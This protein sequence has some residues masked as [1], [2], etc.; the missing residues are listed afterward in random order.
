[1]ARAQVV[2][3]LTIQITQGSAGRQRVSGKTQSNSGFQWACLEL[4][5]DGRTVEHVGTGRNAIKYPE[6]GPMERHAM[7]RL[8]DWWCLLVR[9]EAGPE[10]AM[11]GALESQH[12]IN[13]KTEKR[14]T[15]SEIKP[16]FFYD[17]VVEVGLVRCDSEYRAGLIVC[18]YPI[19]S[20]T[21]RHPGQA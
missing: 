18:R 7:A 17:L 3:L 9:N 2:P 13:G 5:A 20:C 12:M 19:R 16:A 6:L 1:M 10:S 15:V 8:K 14:V 4:K 11:V 21:F